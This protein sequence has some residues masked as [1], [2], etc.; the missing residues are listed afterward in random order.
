ML[1]I[2][3]FY[4]NF[5][6]KYFNEFFYKVQQS[7]LVLN[8]LSALIA[9]ILMII[10]INHFIISKQQP[11]SDAFLLGL[12]IYGVY[13]ATNYATLKNWTINMALTDTLWGATLF[14][15]TTCLTYYIKR[16]IKK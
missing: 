9:Y 3:I 15:L 12:V 7:K 2:D 8:P 10:G 13:D 11:V 4:I 14:S 1:L 16:T 6:K 5:N